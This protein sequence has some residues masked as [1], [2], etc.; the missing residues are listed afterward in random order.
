MAMKKELRAALEA[1]LTEQV[2]AVLGEQY[3][4][5]KRLPKGKEYALYP[6]EVVYADT[7]RPTLGRFISFIPSQKHNAFFIELGWSVDGRFPATS[8]RGIKSP[9]EVTSE[10]PSRGFVRLTEFYSRLGEHWEV[11]PM[12]VLDP[13]S[14]TRAMEFAMRK[15]DPQE[16]LALIRPL[17][18]DAI[19]KV[20]QYAPGFLDA[21]EER[22]RSTGEGTVNR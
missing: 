10:A 15:L 11:E 22:L 5:L 7:S 19:R 16:A 20:R 21:L 8:T 17:A 9:E 13:D 12:D 1:V 18:E 6:G 3:I 14:F 4:R 2:P